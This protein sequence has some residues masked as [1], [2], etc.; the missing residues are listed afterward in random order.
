MQV[1]SLTGEECPDQRQP[2]DTYYD[3][4]SRRLTCYTHQVAALVENFI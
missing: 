1:F 4:S 2:V 3:E